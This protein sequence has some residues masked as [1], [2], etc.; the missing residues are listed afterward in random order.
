MPHSLPPILGIA[1][2]SGSG[3]TALLAGVLGILK[4]RGIRTAVIKRT[5]HEVEVDHPGKDSHRL[6]LAG[7]RQVLLASCGRWALMVEQEPGEEP[8]PEA[9]AAR[10]PPGEQDLVL[11]EGYKAA[12]IPKLEVHR[13]VTGK[14]LLCLNDPWIRAVA[15]DKPLELPSGVPL[16]D[17]NDH[18]AVAEWI[19]TACSVPA[20]ATRAQHA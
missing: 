3:K 20:R 1:G 10:L 11:V 13:P 6:R 12:P 14:P 9:W 7:A 19:V 15:S 18:E 4:Q 2:Y 5:H 16:L 8:G 17:L